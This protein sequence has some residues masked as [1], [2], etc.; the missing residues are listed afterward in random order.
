MSVQQTGKDIVKQ[1]GDLVPV[2]SGLQ[3]SSAISFQCMFLP[4]FI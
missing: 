1:L 4:S 2:L 3:V